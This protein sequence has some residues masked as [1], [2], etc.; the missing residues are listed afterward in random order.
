MKDIGRGNVWDKITTAKPVQGGVKEVRDGEPDG[1][2]ESGRLT[3]TCRD[4]WS[5]VF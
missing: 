5:S 2:K 4:V 3:E 1:L